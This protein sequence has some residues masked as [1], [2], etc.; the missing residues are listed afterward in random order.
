MDELMRCELSSSSRGHPIVEELSV[1]VGL[2]PEQ[3]RHSTAT[4]ER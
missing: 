4:E 2:H 3:R 1:L